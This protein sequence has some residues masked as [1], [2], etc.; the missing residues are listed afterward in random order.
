M[1]FASDLPLYV[2]IERGLFAKHNI[3]VQLIQF[4]AANDMMTALLRGDISATGG[5]GPATFYSIEASDPG[6]FRLLAFAEEN[7]KQYSSLLEV[8][9]NSSIRSLDQLR[10]K[11]I[12]TYTGSTQLL[13]VRLMLEKK[14]GS[15]DAAKIVQVSPS[16]QIAALQRG[17]FDALFCIE[18]VASTAI[19]QGVA[20]VLIANPR[21]K[22]IQN[23]FP[24]AACAASSRWLKDDPNAVKGFKE[25][26]TEAIRL[27]SADPKDANMLLPK[28]TKITREVARVINNYAWYELGHQHSD[29]W[30]KLADLLRENKELNKPLNVKKMYLEP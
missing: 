8:P 14:F 20:R 24:A 21:V 17:D 3:E 28:Y 5:I 9:K 7:E 22:F 26:L 4:T 15:A 12:G 23:P 30:Q 13:N 18:P 6:K 1:G 25:A 16:L 19:V 29:A 27:I 10:G 11:R 2:A